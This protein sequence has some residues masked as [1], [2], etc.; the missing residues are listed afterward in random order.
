MAGL[1]FVSTPT[2][3]PEYDLLVLG[4]GEAGKYIAWT[5]ARKGM[6]T[7]A[8]ERKHVG[9]SCQNIACLPSK[10]VIH[11]AKVASYFRRSEEFGITKDNWRINMRAVRERK[12]KIVTDLVDVQL[13]LYEESR[14]ELVMGSG[15]FV[16]PKTIEV[17]C[18]DGAGPP[19]LNSA[20][21]HCISPRRGRRVEL[22][23]PRR[24]SERL[25]FRPRRICRR[26]ASD[27]SQDS[28]GNAG[29]I[30]VTT[31]D[32]SPVIDSVKRCKGRSGIIKSGK[33]VWRDKEESMSCA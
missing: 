3:Q 13:D 15:G 11:S 16:E 21:R 32:K 2:S 14:A 23:D 8:I 18:A 26:Y 10:N 7:V 28:V 1:K 29:S 17:A 24:G 5:L 25:H 4:S 30:D 9:G 20:R 6:K 22:S 19:M 33:L 31:A 12:R 27:A